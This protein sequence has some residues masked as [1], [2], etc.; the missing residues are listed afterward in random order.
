MPN[1]IHHRQDL[2]ALYL[3]ELLNTF[4]PTEFAL[5]SACMKPDG[6]M[7]R[8]QQSISKDANPS[9]TITLTLKRPPGVKFDPSLRFFFDNF[10]GV[11]YNET[12]LR[13]FVTT[14][15]L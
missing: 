5:S 4:P 9:K 12:N 1:V 8:F 2:R 13:D 10:F 7:E 14:S 6:C 3:A 15:L 11:S